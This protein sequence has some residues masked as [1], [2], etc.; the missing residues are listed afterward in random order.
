MTNDM[1]LKAKIR[2]IAKE[3]NIS[4]QA[5]L[6]NYLMNRFL[7]R[8]SLTGYKEKFV[9]KG[10]MLIA[11]I[12]GIEHRATMDLDTTL[13]NLP[14]TEDSIREAFESI[15]AVQA[16][17]GIT[18]S[19]DSIAPIRDDDEYGGYRVGFSAQFGKINAP[20]SMDVSTG[21]V[22]T[23]GAAKHRFADIL[24]DG[25]SFELWSYPIETVLA[26]KVETILSRG[27]DNTRPRDYYDVYMLS[28]LN[29]DSKMFKDAFIA[30]ASHR[31]S[32]EKI[33]DE[34]GIIQIISES[35]EL[36]RR[37][38][39]YVLQMPYAKGITFSDTINAVRQL[40]RSKDS[41]D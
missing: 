37:W 31:E 26:E 35:S 2:N 39:S 34:E 13:R 27:V 36:N 25:L 23:P 21:D 15:C 22:I 38:D 3:K 32:L 14:L 11:S 4:A 40:L 33:S 19:F 28:G 17:D 20:M 24:E 5:V 16:D 8:L 41:E 18:F 6:Q 30:T 9:I 12:V 10:G 1:S 7:Y 29:Y